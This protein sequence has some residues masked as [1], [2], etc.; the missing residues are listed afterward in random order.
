M[1]RPRQDSVNIFKT[2]P[3]ATLGKQSSKGLRCQETKGVEGAS[4]RQETPPKPSKDPPG[5][6]THLKEGKEIKELQHVILSQ[7]VQIS[8]L[9]KLVMKLVLKKKKSKFVLKKRSTD[10]DSFKRGETKEDES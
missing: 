9:K 4:A 7:Q 1:K 2:F 6:L 10:H 5:W 3:T 8:N